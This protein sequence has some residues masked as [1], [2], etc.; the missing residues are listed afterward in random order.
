M[1]DPRRID[2]AL[3]AKYDVRGPRYTSYP[4]ATQFAAVDQAQLFS[5]WEE[6]NGLSEDPGLSLYFHVPF[7]RARCKMLAS[8]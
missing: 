8:K 3:R 6:R 4:P 5:R 1:Q 7:C 2:A